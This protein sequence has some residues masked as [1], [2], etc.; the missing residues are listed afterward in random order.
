VQAMA[1]VVLSVVVR[2]VP[3]MTAVNGTLV[4]RPARTAWALAMPVD[5]G[6]DR[7]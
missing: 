7:R 6:A 3:V 2:A 5:A 4:G 1:A